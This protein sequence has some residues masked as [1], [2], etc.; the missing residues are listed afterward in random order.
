MAGEEYIDILTPGGTVTVSLTR[1]E[2]EGIIDFA[3]TTGESIEQ[4]VK[5]I[6]A[7][8]H[9][10]TPANEKMLIMPSAVLVLTYRQE[11]D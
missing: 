11:E 6:A 1:S 9:L 3:E 5:A 7:N 10:V 8:N 4:V 2:E